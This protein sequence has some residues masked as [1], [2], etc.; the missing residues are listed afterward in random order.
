MKRPFLCSRLKLKLPMKVQ[1]NTRLD[2]KNYKKKKSTIIYRM[3]SVINIVIIS[4]FVIFFNIKWTCLLLIIFSLI[5]L[6]FP[7]NLFYCAVKFLLSF[8]KKKRFLLSA[9]SNSLILLFRALYIAVLV[10]DQVYCA[11]RLD[12]DMLT[13]RTQLPCFCCKCM[14]KKNE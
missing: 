14:L 10:H 5:N 7:K 1:S 9:L 6:T 4:D 12:D 8:F 13:K 2:E 11:V 3:L